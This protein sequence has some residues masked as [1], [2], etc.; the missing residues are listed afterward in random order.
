MTTRIPSLLLLAAACLLAAC[1]S[2]NQRGSQQAQGNRQA[3]R[4]GTRTATPQAAQTQPRTT[5]SGSRFVNART[6]IGAVAVET[7][8]IAGGALALPYAAN[9]AT[10]DAPSTFDAPAGTGPVMEPPPT[11]GGLP[12]PQ[13]P[14]RG[15]VPP[16]P[17]PPSWE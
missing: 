16:P 6:P 10:L 5:D 1:S 4:Q 2:N 13:L 8:P 11:A 17:P 15:R 12:A 7:S 9:P 3:A 14:P